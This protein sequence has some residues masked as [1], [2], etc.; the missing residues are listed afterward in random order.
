MFDWIKERVHPQDKDNV[1]KEVS[2]YLKGTKTSLDVVFRI[3][4]ANYHC[5]KVHCRGTFSHNKKNKIVIET[6][7]FFEKR[8]QSLISAGGGKLGWVNR[9]FPLHKEIIVFT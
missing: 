5:L 9:S 2:A 7:M 4:D 6:F 3:F 1:L 8:L